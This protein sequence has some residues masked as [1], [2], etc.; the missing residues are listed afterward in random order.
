MGKWTRRLRAL[1][2]ARRLDRDLQDEMRFHLEME[3]EALEGHGAVP[4]GEARRRAMVAFGGVD[5]HAEAHRDARGVRW[6]AELAQDVRYAAR[7]LRRSP[8]FTLS[9]VLVLALGIGATTAAFSAID[10]VLLSRL[11]FRDDHELVRVYQEHSPTNRGT[12]SVVDFRA[13]EEQSRS[14]A[15]VG[16]VRPRRVAVSVQGREPERAGTSQITAGYIAA[17]GV[18]PA[19]GRAIERADEDPAAPAVVIL[20]H[21]YAAR[22]FGSAA[23]A[24]QQ[25]LLIDGLAHTVVGVL[26]PDQTLGLGGSRTE[27]WPALQ[28]RP[29]TRRGPFGLF[30]VG[31]LAPGV[32]LE[33][34]RRDL[35]GISERIFPLWASS[36]QSKN[37]RLSPFPLRKAILGDAPR[38]LGLVA[39]AVA[40]VLLIGVANVASLVL[41]RATAR[42]RE[43]A[44]RTVL[45]ATRGRL[46]R[47]MV[48]ESVLLSALGALVGVGVGAL[49]LRA[50][51]AVGASIPRL[52]AAS[53]DGRA[54]AFAGAVA[55]IAAVAVGAWPVLAL[56]RRDP[57]PAL[58]GGDRTI[59]G[60]AAQR[61]RAAF[62]VAQFSFA[63]PLLAGAGLLLNSFVRLQ[64]VDPGYDERGLL[65]AHV[66][67]PSAAFPGDSAIALFWM[68][69][70]PLVRQVPGVTAVG[71]TAAAPPA[72][73][74]VDENNFDL[75]DRQAPPGGSQPVSPWLQVSEG[76]FEALGLRLL[77]G[78][79]LAPGDSGGAPPVVVVSESWAR[80]YFP[81]GSAVGR[82]LRSGG[83][84]ECPPTTVVGIVGD[85]KYMGLA[86]TSHAVYDPL[87]GGWLRDLDLVVRTAAPPGETASAIRAA[88]RSVD[89]SVPFDEVSTLGERFADAIAEPRH[90]T[91]I[92]GVFAAC[93][94]ALAA[95]GVFGVLSYA[96]SAR[97]REIGVRMA[98]G[99]PADSVVSMFVR[100]GMMLALAGSALGLAASLLAARTISSVLYAVPARDPATLAAVT[101]LLLAVALAASWLPARRASRIDPTEAM[102]AD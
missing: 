22:T 48:T 53:L 39:A 88:L 69:A 102:R 87:A 3:A 26:G 35:A 67:L 76:Y 90:W 75:L 27:I 21:G 81:D 16:I 97:R 33:M 56:L 9:A 45:G 36:Y 79:L 40:L 66:S 64:R 43:L 95:I 25:P 20:G 38:T 55:L 37:S 93:A 24:L 101:T 92:I 52:A 28:L 47:L 85:V 14:F 8:G 5:R 94:L 4:P 32:T 34:A 41:V 82:R 46:V 18:T 31:R 23:A 73:G 84:T 51:A 74:F 91:T 54:L 11:P 98:L 78:R 60:R 2:D 100:R 80:T 1:F 19:T 63:L 12:L 83:C 62:V 15:A 6:A 65:S 10:A 7:G 61:A 29:P 72:P 59:G 13:I 68:R 70:L 50:V 57:A 71:L 89:A 58:H 86:G 30:V 49:A 42:S 77:E 44:L 99:A 17:L 96:V